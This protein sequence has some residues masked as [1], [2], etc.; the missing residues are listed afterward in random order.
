MVTVPVLP[1]R[2]RAFAL[3]SDASALTSETGVEVSVV[4]AAI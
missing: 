1:V 3:P 4:P 2:L